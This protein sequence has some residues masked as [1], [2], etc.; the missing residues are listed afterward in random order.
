MVAIST[1]QSVYSN[2]GT[3]SAK[4]YSGRD[5]SLSSSKFEFY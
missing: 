5:A 2:M 1:E 3:S 4:Q